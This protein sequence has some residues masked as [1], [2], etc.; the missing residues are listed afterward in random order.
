MTHLCSIRMLIVCLSFSMCIGIAFGEN[1][2][3]DVVTATIKDEIVEESPKQKQM[4]RVTVIGVDV[5]TSTIRG[6][7]VEASPEQ[8]PIEGVNVKIVN[9]ANGHEYIITTDENGTY[10]QTGLQQGRYTISVSKRGY[11]DR[12]SRSQVLAAGGEIFNQ[13]KMKKKDNI[14]TFFQRGLFGWILFAS[15]TIGFLLAILALFKS[16]RS[17]NI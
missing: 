5:G 3:T 2:K 11:G 9:A 7:I 8:K 14:I 15:F 1:S 16:L 17:S 12:I 6:E 10:K 4:E 13:T